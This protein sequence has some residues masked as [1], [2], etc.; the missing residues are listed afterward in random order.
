MLRAARTVLFIGLGLI[1][2][3]ADQSP[4]RPLDRP[5][6]ASAK[7]EVG[8][9]EA[10]SLSVVR[11]WRRGVSA[12][13][14]DDAALVPLKVRLIDTKR[15]EDGRHIEE[16]RRYQAWAFAVGTIRIGG[17]GPEISVQPSVDPAEPGPVEWPDGL[18][19]APV[20]W[21]WILGASL[22]LLGAVAL[23]ARRRKRG[24]PHPDPEPTL[25]AHPPHDP[26]AD[27]LRA[28]EPLRARSP[29]DRAE[30]ERLHIDAAAVLRV[31]LSESLG[32]GPE[33]STEEVRDTLAQPNGDA[34][35]AALHPCDMVKFAHTTPGP[36]QG[37]A[38]LDAIESF[39]RRADHS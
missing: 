9:G 15:R 20:P 17:G 24:P 38:M 19:S 36:D 1:A 26:I 27:A 28:L 4:V 6:I 22:A 37:A 5:H 10:F 35:A 21:P 30:I 11:T 25:P 16:T 7:S 34:A 2:A 14:W 18:L 8:F 33:L 39:V 31:F 29:K 3:C 32:A 23:A 12:P 13:E